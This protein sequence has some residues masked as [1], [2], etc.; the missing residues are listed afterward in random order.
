MSATLYLFIN[1]VEELLA[2]PL[3]EPGDLVH[4]SLNVK[5]RSDHA[6]DDLAERFVLVLYAFEPLVGFKVDGD[7]F[8]CHVD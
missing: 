2:Q 3:A 7:G 5:F 4:P 8:G 6:L 1:G